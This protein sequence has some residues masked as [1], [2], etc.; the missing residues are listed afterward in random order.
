MGQSFKSITIIFS[1][2]HV[3]I[4]NHGVGAGPFCLR[5]HGI[6]ETIQSLNRVV[7]TKEIPPVEEFEGE[8]GK[9]FEILRQTARLVKEAR[10]TSSFPIVLAGNCMATV[11]VAAGIQGSKELG[12]VWFDAHDDYHTPSTMTSGYLDGMGVSMLSGESFQALAKTIPGYSPLSLQRFIYCGLRDVNE[13]ERQRV[14][15]AGMGIVWGDA[16]RKVDFKNELGM[17]LNKRQLRDVMVHLDLDALDTS[18][19]QV[20]QFSAPGGLFEDDLEGCL[21]HITAKTQPVSLTVASF[22][23]SLG[24]EQSISPI[25][26]RVITKFVKAIG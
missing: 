25:A 3:G 17:E 20:N 8:I 23:P 19:G 24:G 16:D 21:E 14:T 15:G 9:S 11:G 22:N 12:C 1:P 13:V 6:I 5:K 2:Y 10:D 26:I 4:Y 7:I 18:L